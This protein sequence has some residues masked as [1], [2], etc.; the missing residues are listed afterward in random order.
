MAKIAKVGALEIL[1]SRGNPTVRVHVGARRRHG[2]R[3][4][5]CLRA[6]RP[7]RT[8]RSSCATAT[9]PATAARAC[10]K[11]V[12]NVVET[13]APAV[14][15]RD[16]ARQ[17]EIDARDARARRHAEQGEARRQR[18][19]RRVDG[20]RPRGGA[21]GEAAALRLSRRRRRDPPAGADDEHRQ[22]RQ[23]RREFGRLPGIHGDAGRRAELR[24]GVCATAPKPSTRWRSSSRARATRRRSATKA[25]LRP[26]SAATRRPA[27]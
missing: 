9:R 21:V 18:H 6:R 27:N 13:I 10:C 24:R 12:A 5:R 17:A 3:P 22:R 16:P 7:A 8:R 25:A 1:D 2:R 14:I 15:G 19:S 20:G 26:I 11:A 4:P 23:A